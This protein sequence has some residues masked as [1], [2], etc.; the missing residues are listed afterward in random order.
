M[1]LSCGYDRCVVFLA[2]CHISIDPHVLVVY[3]LFCS[4]YLTQP[5]YNPS[6]YH[7]LLY[8]LI[9]ICTLFALYNVFFCHVNLSALTPPVYTPAADTSS[10]SGFR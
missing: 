1:A 6:Y 5:V 9:V 10:L 4:C 3:W 7:C 8:A 2:G